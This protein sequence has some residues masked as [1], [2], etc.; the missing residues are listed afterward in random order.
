MIPDMGAVAAMVSS[1]SAATQITKVM[2][3]LRDA[4]MIQSKVIELNTE[5]LSA[6]A[7]AFAANQ[8]QTALLERIG[9]LEKE[10]AALKTWEAEKQNYQFAEVSSGVFAYTP[11]ADM[12]PPKPFHMLCANCYERGEKS[13]L[14]ATQ[15]LRMRRRVHKCPR[16][17]SE[18]EMEHVPKPPPPPQAPRYSPFDRRR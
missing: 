3:G 12:E 14:Q 15:E 10:I 5:I 4:A 7:S 13:T 6:Q 11:K 1:I 16:C 18:Y 2:L 9:A 8:A 17:Q